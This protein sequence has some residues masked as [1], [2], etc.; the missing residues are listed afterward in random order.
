L[1]L[2]DEPSEGVQPNIVAQIGNII[3]QIN[4]ELG[5]TVLLVEQNLDLIQHTAHRCYVM[6]KGSI[7]ADLNRSQIADQTLLIKHLAI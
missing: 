5:V 3:A 1:L 4:S 7:V 6:E 2:L